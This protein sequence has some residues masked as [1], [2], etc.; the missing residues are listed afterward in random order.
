MRRLLELR[1]NVFFGVVPKPEDKRQGPRRYAC[2]SWHAIAHARSIFGPINSD[3]CSLPSH[4]DWYLEHQV[5]I[6]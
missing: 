4:D 2:A 1:D 5:R 6:F 3:M